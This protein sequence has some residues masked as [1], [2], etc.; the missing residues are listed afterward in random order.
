MTSKA[1]VVWGKKDEVQDRVRVIG[2]VRESCGSRVHWRGEFKA[3]AISDGY[4]VFSVG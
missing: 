1:G 4:E 2:V 3:E